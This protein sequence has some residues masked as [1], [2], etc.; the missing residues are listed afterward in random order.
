M[1]TLP[2]HHGAVALDFSEINDYGEVIIERVF[3]CKRL[4][5]APGVFNCCGG[6]WVGN[7]IGTFKNHRHIPSDA[8]WDNPGHIQRVESPLKTLIAHCKI[9]L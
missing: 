4:Y 9:P 8:S 2:D 5:S 3:A 1:T 6:S 7:Y